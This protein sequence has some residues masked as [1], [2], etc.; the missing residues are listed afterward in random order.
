M[1]WTKEQLIPHLS[2]K[3]K[4]KDGDLL[5]KGHKYLGRNVPEQY[6][7]IQDWCISQGVTNSAIPDLTKTLQGVEYIIQA[8]VDNDP[9]VLTPTTLKNCMWYL[10]RPEE[11]KNGALRQFPEFQ[12]IIKKELLELPFGKKVLKIISEIPE[13]S[14]LFRE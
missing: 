1:S 12:E 7:K 4:P 14:D 2:K 10:N 13:Y 3:N 8:A 6:F 5:E 9:K 11:F